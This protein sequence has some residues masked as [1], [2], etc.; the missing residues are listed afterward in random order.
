M[1]WGMVSMI[2]GYL[3]RDVWASWT[4]FFSAEELSACTYETCCAKRSELP[5]P[6]VRLMVALVSPQLGEVVLDLTCG[7][8]GFAVESYTTSCQASRHCA[9]AVLQKLKQHSRLRSETTALLLVNVNL[10]LRQVSPSTPAA[11]AF[12]S[13]GDHRVDVILSTRRLV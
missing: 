3:L 10:L 8:G 2:N 9:G 11:C 1:F 12:R 6:M 4:V 13:G 7:T 5:A